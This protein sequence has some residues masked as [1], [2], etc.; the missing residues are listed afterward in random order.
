MGFN[1][2]RM[3]TVYISGDNIISPLDFTTLQNFEKLKAG[4]SG[5]KLH[6]DTG[7]SPV[8]FQAS[9]FSE[10]QVNH[11]NESIPGNYSLFERLLIM[12][13][14][15]GLTHTGIDPADSRTVFIISS[16]KGNIAKIEHPEGDDTPENISLHR[17]A[18][19][20]AGSFG[21]KN[22][23]LVVSS[24]CISGVLALITGKRLIESEI[25]DNAVVVGADL[26]TR[27]ILSGFQS[28]QAVSGE[29]CRPFDKSRNG[30]TLG[31][32]AA[33]IILSAKKPTGIEPVSIA[34]GSTS[35]DANH[36]S[37]PSRTG[38]PLYAAIR[39]ALGQSGISA[40]Q[41]GFISAH[42]TATIFNDEME[43]KAISLAGLEFAPVNSLKG[44]YGHTLGAAGLIEAV[45]SVQS[46]RENTVIATKGFQESGV[47]REININSA[48]QKRDMRYILKTAS[49]FG[50]CNAAIVLEKHA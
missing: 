49:G 32:G 21:N 40:E 28:F 35:N 13:A 46:L 6:E 1:R 39:K 24:A 5:I 19:L 14:H 18:K 16:T 20:V 4:V 44:Y 27:F 30:V 11:V 23:P 3:R 41:V 7:R 25:Y 34:G 29:P 8:P 17:S 12:S 43:A 48:L 36:I 50:G 15:A 33:T 22:L 42:G 47:S 9:L 10:E 2:E 31:E 45:I 37:G 38:E 26:I